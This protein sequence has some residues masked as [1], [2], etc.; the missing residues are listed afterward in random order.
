VRISYIRLQ[1]ICIELSG[2][3]VPKQTGPS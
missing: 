2:S 3:R 1:I